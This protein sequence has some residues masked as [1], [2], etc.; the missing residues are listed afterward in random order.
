MKK[1]IINFLSL[2]KIN[3]EFKREFQNV[4]KRVLNNGNL[5]LSKETENFEKD[6]A[7]YCGAKYAVAVSNG[8]DALRLVLMA[9]KIG[10][11]DE[12]IVPYNTHI[13]L[14]KWL[15]ALVRHPLKQKFH[16]FLPI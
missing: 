14:D 13:Y 8:L 3:L 6:F 5:L 15:H 12:V 4:L 1:K 16:I 11:G 9:K 2:K 10:P 7:K